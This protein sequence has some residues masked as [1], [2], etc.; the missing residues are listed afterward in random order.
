LLLALPSVARGDPYRFTKIADGTTAAPDGNGCLTGFY[1]P[2]IDGSAVAFLAESS[3]SDNDGIYMF[4]GGPLSTV[5][6]E[7][8]PV[9]GMPGF[10]FSSINHNIPL[11]GTTVAFKANID[12]GVNRYNGVFTASGGTITKIADTNS[13]PMPGT[14]S[15]F[16]GLYP[17]ALSGG[18]VAFKGDNNSGFEGIYSDVTGSLQTV[19]DFNTPVPNRPPDS[20][21]TLFD[22]YY[23]GR[24]SFDGTTVA[25][26]AR[27]DFNDPCVPG[28]NVTTEYGV[29]TASGGTITT[30]AD[31]IDTN[32]PDGN[33]VFDD[34]GPPSIDG[35]YVV[36]RGIDANGDYGMYTNLGGTLRTVA[37]E[38][39]QIPGA[40]GTFTVFQ[41]GSTI[42]G[43]NILVRGYGAS[44]FG[45]YLEM[46]G[47]L[48]KV[49]DTNDTL[50]GKKFDDSVYEE[51]LKAAFD[52]ALSGDEIA[53]YTEFNDGSNGVYVSTLPANILVYKTSTKGTECDLEEGEVEKVKERGYLVVDVTLVDLSVNAA[54]LVSYGKD[55]DKWQKT[56]R[57]DLQF[58]LM[59]SGNKEMILAQYQS[60]DT[61]GALTSKAGDTEIGTANKELVPKSLKS[62]VLIRNANTF[63]SGKMQ[64]RLYGG[65]TKEANE[66]V[67]LI[68][69]VVAEIEAA[70]A[71]KGYTP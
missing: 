57:V 28:P 48:D 51:D 52:R 46:D 19:V 35:G 15:V 62:Y 20:N 53:I 61:T 13:T 21:F 6:I 14:G 41:H 17:P 47:Q 60:N 29:F 59:Q 32:V 34:L 50:D 10:W 30:I 36:F 67:K 44:T 65:W 27:F 71:D 5:V 4:R 42:D 22:D 39:T 40:A 11:E 37:N 70:L 43:N 56:E 2:A 64:A 45:I 58:A 3:Y 63:G 16:D 8:M 12:N 38:Q 9:P 23:K 33:G 49:I 66:E 25:F 18:K 31:T 55:G 1:S 69:E 26:W 68:D 54:K 7:D 24:L